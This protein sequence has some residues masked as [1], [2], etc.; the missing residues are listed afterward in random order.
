M[1]LTDSANV[2]TVNA[3]KLQKAMTALAGLDQQAERN[4]LHGSVSVE[5]VYREGVASHVVAETRATYK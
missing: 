2:N 3:D 4:H 5:I 1:P